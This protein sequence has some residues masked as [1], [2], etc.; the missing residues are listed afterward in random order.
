MSFSSLVSPEFE[1]RITT[2]SLV[3]MPKSPWDAS[4]GWI[5]NDG[6]PVEAKVA[7][8]FKCEAGGGDWSA[9]AVSGCGWGWEQSSGWDGDG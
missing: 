3:I 9:A 1:R 8:E 6:V 5:K 7:G 2:S 4:P